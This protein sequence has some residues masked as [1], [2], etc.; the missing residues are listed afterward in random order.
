MKKW[1]RQSK[2]GSIYGQRKSGF[3]HL[4]IAVLGKING[5]RIVIEV[6][7][8]WYHNHSFMK[9]GEKWFFIHPNLEPGTPLLMVA[10]VL[11]SSHL[12]QELIWGVENGSDSE[13]LPEN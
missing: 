12:R 11:L 9:Q 13:Q 3:F 8:L 7:Q 4:N 10:K 6:S 1:F 2:R 5:F